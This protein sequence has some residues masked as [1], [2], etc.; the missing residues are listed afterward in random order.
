[1]HRNA[2]ETE[3]LRVFIILWTFLEAYP[4]PP[5]PPQD[6]RWSPLNSWQ[7]QGCSKFRRRARPHSA[8]H[9]SSSEHIYGT[10]PAIIP[11]T[12]YAVA[13]SLIKCYADFMQIAPARRKLLAKRDELECK[14]RHLGDQS[15]G[16]R[17]RTFGCG[18][19]KPETLWLY[20]EAQLSYL[21]VYDTE[22]QIKIFGIWGPPEL[23]WTVKANVTLSLETDL[24]HDTGRYST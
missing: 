24:S 5:P 3:I 23:M 22:W 8:T 2:R 9:R 17:I 15:I 16:T 7:L 12:A 11:I 4:S 18:T 21:V 10:F 19:T 13:D 20:S 1:M 14:F 6:A